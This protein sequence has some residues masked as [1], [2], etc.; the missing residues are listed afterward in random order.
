MTPIDNAVNWCSD[1][2]AAGMALI[3]GGFAITWALLGPPPVGPWAP[4]ASA[5]SCVPV[6]R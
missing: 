5:Y 3:I 4:H 6:S 1:H 2:I